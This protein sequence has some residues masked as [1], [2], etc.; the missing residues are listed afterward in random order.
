[1]RILLDLQ[2]CQTL[3]RLRGIGRYSMAL[4]RGIIT[5]AGDHEVYVGVSAATPETIAPIKDALADVLPAERFKVWASVEPTAWADPR[6]ADRFRLAQVTREAF[7]DRLNV[8][9]VHCSSVV[10]GMADNAVTSIGEHFVGAPTAATLYDLIPALYPKDYLQHPLSERWFRTQ[11]GALRRADLL[12]AI[13]DSAATEAA[14]LLGIPRTK[15]VNIRGA[16]DSIFVPRSFTDVEEAD[17]RAKF[18]LPKPFVLYSGGLDQRKNVA[19]LIEAFAMLPTKLRDSHQIGIVG[20][21]HSEAV[22]DLQRI[23]AAA[24]LAPGQVSFTGYVTDDEIVSLYNLAA[25]FAFPSHHEGFG[26]PPLEAM[27]CGTPTIA[28]NN[29]SMPEVVALPEALFDSRDPAAL[30]AKLLRVLTD[31]EF[32]TRLR[33]HGLQQAAT[34]AWNQSARTALEAFEALHEQGRR[35]NVPAVAPRRPRLALVSELP[36]PAT[37]ARR[38]VV[39]TIE[40]LNLHY[41]VDL[42]TQTDIQAVSE[43]EAPAGLVAAEDFHKVCGRYDRVLYRYTNS[44]LSGF[45]LGLQRT[46]PG[47]VLLEDASLDQALPAVPTPESRRAALGRALVTGYGYDALSQT[48]ADLD[49]GRIPPNRSYVDAILPWANGVIV[50]QEAIRTQLSATLGADAV[51]DWLTLPSLAAGALPASS[52]SGGPTM[53]AAFG[54]IG[55]PQLLHRVV[56]AWLDTA[57]SHDPTATLALVGPSLEGSYGRSLAQ[58]LAA[59]PRPA[60]W[61]FV[62]E[63]EAEDLMGD[64]R[65]AVHLGTRGNRAAL[66]WEQ[67]CAAREVPVLVQGSA[68]LPVEFGQGE[69]VA[70]LDAAW[71]RPRGNAD[72]PAAPSEPVVDRYAEAIESWEQQGPLARQVN[73][74]RTAARSVDRPTSEDLAMV[75]HAVVWNDPLP[76]PTRQL[77]LD[78]SNVVF[79][80]ARTGIQRVVRNIARELVLAPPAGFRVEPVYADDAGRFW[81]ARAYT[82]RLLGLPRTGLKDEPLLTAPGDVFIGLDMSQRLFPRQIQ[83]EGND[84]V[85]AEGAVEHLRANGVVTQ[86]VVYDLIP[87]EHPDWFPDHQRAFTAW[88]EGVARRGDGLLAISQATADEAAAWVRDVLPAESALPISWFH[89]GADID[90]RGDGGALTPAFARRWEQL[91][92][93]L[94]F[95]LVGTIEPRKGVDQAIAA[96][97]VL[98]R[99]GVN[100]NLVLVGHAGWK[101]DALIARLRAHPD[102]GRLCWFEAASDA[103]LAFLY[104]HADAVLLASR[105]E[106]FGLP[107]IE[108]AQHGTPLIARDLPVFREVAGAHATYFTGEDGD[109]LATVLRAWLTDRERGVIPDSAALPW[110]TWADSSAQLVA[111]IR[112]N[113]A[114]HEG[115]HRP[116]GPSIY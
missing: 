36:A 21:S 13:S 49:A 114:V 59:S 98:W 64:M 68:A 110:L 102:G 87:I 106:G 37:E 16:A 58:L 4:A 33:E 44:P 52:A 11:V 63:A 18:R 75:A 80:D 61:R 70:A 88:L 83:L 104:G 62:T 42:V 67:A 25:A 29:S 39:N 46:M 82:A 31:D 72:V 8:D 97:E 116:E 76:Q 66:A 26:L 32:R 65:V 84:I 57:A 35:R 115:T 24:G 54:T 50:T 109:S 71:R 93:G 60:G 56:T 15:I 40:Q 30:Q 5:N 101:Q 89:L 47:T 7:L 86:F 1:M 43:L 112:R 111:A 53:V 20:A 23:A 10:E 77:L 105:A 22:D 2:G 19:G 17:L 103:E 108:A 6:N 9:I 107:L 78:V 3:S 79:Y 51:R 38:A 28:A 41:R 34:F 55:S 99:E 85:P 94:T 14:E 96:F 48:L 12:L 91:P 113:L 81:Y 74:I 95:L 92:Q 73:S 90:E 45:L 100:V 69:L 27:S